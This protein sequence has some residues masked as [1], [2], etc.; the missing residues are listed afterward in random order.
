MEVI[1]ELPEAPKAVFVNRR[2]THLEFMGRFTDAE[3]VGIYTAAKSSVAVEI[4]LDKFKLASDVDKDDARTIAGLQ[5]LETAGLLAAG[6]A[7]EI[8]A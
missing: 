1:F 2:I 6:R 5:A 3:L 8:L 4:W 7:A